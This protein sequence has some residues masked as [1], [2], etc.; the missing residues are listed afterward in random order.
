MPADSFPLDLS[1]LAEPPITAQAVTRAVAALPRVAEAACALLRAIDLDVP[2]LGL[3][4]ESLAYGGLQGGPDHLAWRAKRKPAGQPAL[5]GRVHVVRDG[6]VINI[7]LDRPLTRNAIDRGMRDT[8]FEAFTVAA[9]DPDV[10]TVRLRGLGKAFCVGADLDEFGTTLDPAEAHRIR[11]LTLPALA[12]LPSSH[13]FEVHVQGACIGSGLEMA[14]F[15]HR[16]TASPD[17]WFQLPEL[18]MGLIPGAGGCVSISRR[19]GRNRT[20]LLIL[21]G[22]R[23]NARTALNWGLIDAIVE[24][25]SPADRHSDVAF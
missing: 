6:D 7:L 15:A 5:P 20:A 24:D 16:F 23:I 18:A 25:V 21:S 8:L 9:L 10:Q 22:K 1:S 3:I 12:I 11:M 2:A 14:A 17:A 13:K 4:E 19:I